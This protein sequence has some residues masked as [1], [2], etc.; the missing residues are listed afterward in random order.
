[1]ENIM[2][3]TIALAMALKWKKKMGE[4]APMSIMLLSFVMYIPAVLL[5]LTISYYIALGLTIVAIVY[6]VY[7][8]IY[9]KETVIEQIVSFSSLAFVFV[10]VFFAIFSIG[11]GF[12]DYDDLICWALKVKNMVLYSELN[13]EMSTSMGQVY[14]PATMLWEYLACKTWIG[15]GGGIVLWAYT[16][17]IASCTL[18]LTEFTGTKNRTA[19]ALIILGVILL[20]PLA[21]T[22]KAYTRL[23]SDVLIANIMFYNFYMLKRF[24]ETKDRYF[25]VALLMGVYAV[26]MSKRIGIV[27]GGMVL[28]AATYLCFQEK[29]ICIIEHKEKMILVISILVMCTF[30]YSL[31]YGSVLIQFENLVSYKEIVEN[32]SICIIMLFI[33]Y[34]MAKKNFVIQSY[35]RTKPWVKLIYGGILS[36][37]AFYAIGALFMNNDW[38]CH[39][40]SVYIQQLFSTEQS[41]FG[42]LV[43]LATMNFYIIV[44]LILWGLRKKYVRNNMDEMMQLDLNIAFLIILS[45]SIYL[46]VLLESYI[47]TIGL[48]NS[49]MDLPS[50]ER[51]MIPCWLTITEWGIYMWLQKIERNSWKQYMALFITMIFLANPGDLIQYMLI[52]YRQP[53]YLGIERSGVELTKNDNIYYV[54]GNEDNRFRTASFFYYV[55]P[56]KS[57]YSG[58][59]QLDDGQK[60][61]S[62]VKFAEEIKAGGYNY[63]YI[64]QL[65]PRFI[66]LYGS[67]FQD[68][69]E[70][71][72]EHIYKIEYNNESVR[73]TLIPYK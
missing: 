2:V 55:M 6:C 30:S 37:F 32:L 26:T 47:R 27:F 61:I 68:K 15:Y 56:A 19:K 5:T 62:V 46:V 18:P 13:S 49:D 11:R 33:G 35:N 14:P 67:L 57:D 20:L 24:I 12:Y 71:A 40:T 8:F 45:M 50:F 42:N 21:G 34:C 31:Y 29:N 48:E 69:K 23:S 66:G 44:L 52:K 60:P 41:H 22:S 7:Y 58:V 3:Y 17:Y 70:I 72:P 25:L 65:D 9:Q 28:L 43:P 53:E 38:A 10:I 54:N 16:V 59:L 51:Y 1:M 39:V 36:F 63:L 64:N 4:T 73:F